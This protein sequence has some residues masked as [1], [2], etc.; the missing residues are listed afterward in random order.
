MNF[1]EINNQFQA[2]ITRLTIFWTSVEIIAFIIGMWTLYFV[3]KTA[4]RD[5][6]NESNLVNSWQK[7]ARSAIE[8][9][10]NT[11]HIPDI[12]PDR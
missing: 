1:T 7:T 4:I 11:R 12:R 2:E 3:I 6:I 5:G 8:E 10:A 9:E